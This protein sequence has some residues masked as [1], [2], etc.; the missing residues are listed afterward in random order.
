[1]N[2]TIDTWLVRQLLFAILV[3]QV[4]QQLLPCVLN[5]KQWQIQR[6]HKTNRAI[7][8]GLLAAGSKHCS[9]PQCHTAGEPETLEV[10]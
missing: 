7:L 8:T 4:G 1:M 2:T 6:L 3:G 9:L 10:L 5:V